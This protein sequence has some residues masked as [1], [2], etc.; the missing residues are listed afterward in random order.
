[1]KFLLSRLSQERQQKERVDTLETLQGMGKA[2]AIHPAAL[3]A[4]L[5]WYPTTIDTVGLKLRWQGCAKKG[6]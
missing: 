5:P 6:E 2:V 1:M 3:S 4:V